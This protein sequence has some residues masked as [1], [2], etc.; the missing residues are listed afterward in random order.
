MPKEV[1]AV[2]AS[3]PGV[4]DVYAAG[5]PDARWG[6]VR[7]AWVVPEPRA[8]VDPDEVL[9]LCKGRLAGFK[10]PKHVLLIEAAELPLTPTGKVQK[11]ILVKRAA[12][13][14]DGAHGPNE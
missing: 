14:L 7:C 6:E 3:H 1:E 5:I 10:V 9:A 4:S 2:I 8:S 11:F 12:E 13:M